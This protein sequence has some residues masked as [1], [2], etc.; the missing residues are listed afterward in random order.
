MDELIDIVNLQGEPTGN[1]CLKSFAHQ[2]GI[3]HA[4]VH[5]WL[6]T[7]N[8]EIL[9]QKRKEDKET[10]PNLW[11]VSVA[12]H[13]AAGETAINAALREVKEEV[14]LTLS[15][16]GLKYIGIFEEKHQHANGI[17]D[18]EI[19][20]IYLAQLNCDLT[21]LTPQKEEVS[22]IKLISLQ[23]FEK[24]YKDSNVY[25]AHHHEYYHYIIKKLKET[26]K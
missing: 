14:D 24:N 15:K 3:L 2:N 10:F 26:N 21:A 20:H 13:I 7:S 9:I 6:Y 25:V 5:I 8:Q 22:A 12:G 19:H 17:I 4:S 16:K 18:H 23:E 11:D 1:A